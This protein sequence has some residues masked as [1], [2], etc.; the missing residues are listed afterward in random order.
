MHT[1]DQKDERIRLLIKDLAASF[2]ERR[3]NRTPLVTVTDVHLSCDRATVDILL[4]VLP[5]S[6]APGA[7]DFANRHRDELKDELKARSRLRVIP[8]VRFALDQGEKNR[9]RID[10]LSREAEN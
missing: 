9:Q 1:H 4:S 7:V 10:E 5:E 8:R 2:L 6:G 3:V